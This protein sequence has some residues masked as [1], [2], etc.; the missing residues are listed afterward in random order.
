M[1]FTLAGYF[2]ILFAYDPRLLWLRS[3]LTRK[4]LV[5][6]CDALKT[7]CALVCDCPL[8]EEKVHSLSNINIDRFI[9][10]QYTQTFQK[11]LVS[12]SFLEP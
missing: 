11:R 4:L 6:R 2:G 7:R 1:F 8:P 12:E 10:S 3:T 5:Q 9:S